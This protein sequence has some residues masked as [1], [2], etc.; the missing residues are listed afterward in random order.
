MKKNFMIALVAVATLSFAACNTKT[1]GA[2]KTDGD[3]TS[4]AADVKPAEEG[5]ALDKYA[6][7]VEKMVSL[8]EKA[9]SGDAAATEELA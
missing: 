5:S 1:D 2:T 8:Q 6:E 7:L 9:K 4:V 3:S